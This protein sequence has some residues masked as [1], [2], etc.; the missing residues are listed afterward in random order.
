MS[1]DELACAK[2][3]DLPCVKEEAK[4]F[5][6]ASIVSTLHQAIKSR[7]SAL[8]ASIISLSSEEQIISN[9]AQRIS[10]SFIIPF[11]DLLTE[12][13]HLGKIGLRGIVVW[14]RELL[15]NQVAYFASTPAAS[16]ALCRLYGQMEERTL[17]YGNL[18]GLMGKLDLLLEQAKSFSELC[19]DDAGEGAVASFVFG[20]DDLECEAFEECE[21][22]DEGM[23]SE[24]E[25]E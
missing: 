3:E 21:Q 2:P 19:E 13:L 8:F 24:E 1:S 14:V 16:E 6:P 11:L 12:Q 5:N 22:G 23:T 10:P 17:G 4:A 9:T 7:D 15:G 25:Y 20:E 18:I